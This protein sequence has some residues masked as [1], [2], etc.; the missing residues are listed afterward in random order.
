MKDK[1]FE[2]A[3][4]RE[5]LKINALITLIFSATA[6]VGVIILF[7]IFNMFTTVRVNELTTALYVLAPT[8][9]FTFWAQSLYNYRKFKP[10][11]RY[12]YQRETSRI[13]D[14]EIIT[15]ATISI[16]EFP[17]KASTI[18]FLL[19]LTTGFILVI[20][21]KLILNTAIAKLLYILVAVFGGASAAYIFLY[22]L[23][24]LPLKK[25][26]FTLLATHQGKKI[27]QEYKLI[28]TRTKLIMTIILII[29]STISIFGLLSYSKSVAV[30][31]SE[32][33]KIAKEIFSSLNGISNRKVFINKFEQLEKEFEL[34]STNF[35]IFLYDMNHNKF[36]FTNN[37]YTRSELD[38]A[39][40]KSSIEGENIKVPRFATVHFNLLPEYIAVVQFP[41]F[42]SMEIVNVVWIILVLALISIVL[43]IFLLT[44]F[45]NE[46]SRPITR[47]KEFVKY[48]KEGDLSK[49]IFIVSDDELSFIA[50]LLRSYRDATIK[51]VKTISKYAT[52]FENETAMI[53]STTQKLEQKIEDS[54]FRQLFEKSESFDTMLS[55]T[56]KTLN[57]SIHTLA[58]LYETTKLLKVSVADLSRFNE[59]T[60]TLLNSLDFEHKTAQKILNEMSVNMNTLMG[61]VDTIEKNL[62]N[63]ISNINSEKYL[64]THT[65][66]EAQNLHNLQVIFRDEIR[67]LTYSLKE[68]EGLYNEMLQNLFNFR[69]NLEKAKEMAVRIGTISENSELIS[70]NASIIAVSASY[71]FKEFSIISDELRDLTQRTLGIT[72]GIKEKV[73]WISYLESE[74][75]N[76]VDISSRQFKDLISTISNIDRNNV[77]AHQAIHRT[78]E[79]INGAEENIE[80][81]E[82][83]IQEIES[84]FWKGRRGLEGFST[85]ITNLGNSLN[86]VKDGIQN[87]FNINL[88]LKDALI[89]IQET[90]KGILN[91]FRKITLIHEDSEK[92]L[93]H[94]SLTARERR[95]ITRETEKTLQELASQLGSLAA[96]KDKLEKNVSTLR[97]IYRL[98]KW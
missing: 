65:G 41:D 6:V 77:E 72:E 59:E 16:L 37:K 90:Y 54:S 81:I 2:L 60:L 85:S 55:N 36:L 76:K 71:Y 35:D 74:I 53:A 58:S 51:I 48:M 15:K 98:F 92:L 31:I 12:L 1:I 61:S 24:K 28:S 29:I 3:G 82:D 70:F 45:S 75:Y 9:F 18:S 89:T 19:W 38:G 64:L 17:L 32:E 13:I 42:S 11:A 67:K 63:L 14:E 62:N 8:L 5:G 52:Q 95:N 21:L 33:K 30:T 87:L 27:Q 43:S 83:T 26:A 10:I 46:I 57:S 23:F 20:S 22:Y 50:Q 86:E 44:Y 49:K 66:N 96:A 91:S 68:L 93:G 88:N 40:L 69:K 25:T 73:D 97:D 34:H 94:L 7:I 84:G 39:I 47:T 80:I 56:Q 78:K 79:L 4:G